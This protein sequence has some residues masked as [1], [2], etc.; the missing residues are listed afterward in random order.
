MADYLRRPLLTVIRLTLVLVAGAALI[1]PVAPVLVVTLV[2]PGAA[3][4]LVLHSVFRV[5]LSFMHL[6]RVIFRL[7]LSV[8]YQ[9]A[10]LAHQQSPFLIAPTWP[11]RGCG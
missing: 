10:E 9:I 8:T 2:L 4:E 5:L 7:L 11:S 6:L 1:L 3:A